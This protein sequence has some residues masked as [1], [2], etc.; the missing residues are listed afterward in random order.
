M[1]P[2]YVSTRRGVSMG[3]ELA[4]SALGGGETSLGAAG[5]GVARAL[6]G[7]AGEVCISAATGR[8]GL[9]AS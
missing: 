5:S 1:A 7:A 6:A 9:Q 3:A 2:S 4:A 8:L